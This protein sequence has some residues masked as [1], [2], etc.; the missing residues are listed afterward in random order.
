V[1]VP[2]PPQ[3]KPLVVGI[4]LFFGLTLIISST[5]TAFGPGIDGSLIRITIHILPV[6]LFY[7]ALKFAPLLSATRE[8]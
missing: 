6:V 8:R 2:A 3:R 4:F 7:G 5:G 1:F